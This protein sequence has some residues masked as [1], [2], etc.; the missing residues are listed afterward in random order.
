LVV[1]GVLLYGYELYEAILLL[2]FPNDSGAIFTLAPLLIGIY[3]LGMARAWHLLGGRSYRLN[4][5]LSPLHDAEGG[6]ASAAPDQLLA[7]SDV[8]DDK[9]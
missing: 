3:A 9:S 5:W 7:A 6:Q 8:K 2:R 1:A 4:D